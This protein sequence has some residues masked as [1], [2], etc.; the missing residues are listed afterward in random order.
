VAQ[1]RIYTVSFLATAV[2]AQVDLFELTPADD[3]PIEVMGLFIGQSSDAGDT[4]AE[5]LAYSVIR[6][7][8]TSG[9]GG[10][11][12]TPAKTNRSDTA[13]GFTAETCNTTLATTGTTAQ[14][15]A[16]TFHVASG[17]KLWLPEG[18]EWEASQADTTIVVRLQAAPAD[19]LTMSATVYVREQG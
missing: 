6:G 11:A 3:K 17:E 4:Q 19:S 8:T 1:N 15:H 7:F 10:A 13:A 9:S 12:P 16:D 18:C 2:T 5:L 14:I